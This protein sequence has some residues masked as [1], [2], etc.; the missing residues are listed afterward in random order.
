MCHYD[1]FSSK[2]YFL[3][4][5]HNKLKD[6]NFITWKYT[7][8]TKPI[9]RCK[10][11]YA[12][13]WQWQDHCADEHMP[14]PFLKHSQKWQNH[15]ENAEVQC[16]QCRQLIPSIRDQQHC[17]CLARKFANVPWKMQVK[18]CWPEGNYDLWMNE[19]S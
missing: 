8:L 13:G 17:L 7:R 19:R 10:F 14:F 2:K 9:H 3:T 1:T 15:T 16:S 6:S 12:S 18:E 4:Y 11:K 5:C